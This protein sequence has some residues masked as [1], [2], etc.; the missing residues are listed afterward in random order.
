MEDQL[1][2]RGSYWLDQNLSISQ[3]FIQFGKQYL[4]GLNPVYWFVPNNPQDLI[5][6]AGAQLAPIVA[7]G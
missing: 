2:M 1:R 6:L 7:K 4:T 5:R 3:K